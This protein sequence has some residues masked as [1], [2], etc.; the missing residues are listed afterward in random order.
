MN[1]RVLVLTLFTLINTHTAWSIEIH[2]Y[3]ITPKTGINENNSF[4]NSGKECLLNLI[5]HLKELA[6]EFQTSGKNGLQ[7]IAAPESAIKS[8]CPTIELWARSTEKS[9]HSGVE[10]ILF[11]EFIAEIQELSMNF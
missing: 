4:G 9:E 7:V 11:Y 8:F 1:Y 6:V 2:P 3:F 5:D 10:K